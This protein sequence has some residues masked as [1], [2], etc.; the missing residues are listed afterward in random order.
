[1]AERPVFIS[2]PESERLVEE[3]FFTIKWHSGFAVTQKEKNIAA[4]HE[5]AKACGIAPLL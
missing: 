1:M 4:L 2:A 3:R 5:A